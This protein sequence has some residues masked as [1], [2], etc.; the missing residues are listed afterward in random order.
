MS[1]YD[2]WPPAPIPLSRM[3]RHLPPMWLAAAQTAIPREDEGPFHRRDTRQPRCHDFVTAPALL[4]DRVLSRLRHHQ[5]GT[6]EAED[7][8]YIPPRTI[9]IVGAGFSGTSV[10]TNLLRAGHKQPVRVVLV[11]RSE[12]GRGVAY[13]RAKEAYLLNVPASRMSANVDD[14]DEF[15]K[16]AQRR[17]PGAR[18]E[19]FLPRELY[20]EYLDIL[21]AAGRERGTAWGRAAAYARAGHRP[22]AHSAHVDLSGSSG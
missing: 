4:Y 19:D 7:M 11:D 1:G 14:P 22:R 9:V 16:F 20:G 15:L 8:A 6:S 10:A 12:I 13:R 2:A 5:C 21:T 18:G 17:L 3:G